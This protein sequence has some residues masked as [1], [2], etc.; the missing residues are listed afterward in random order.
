MAVWPRRTKEGAE[1][2]SPKTKTKTKTET[3]TEVGS[4]KKEKEEKV[5]SCSVRE[6]EDLHQATPCFDW[7]SLHEVLR[8]ESAAVWL[9]PNQ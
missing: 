4:S 8:G 5:V 9:T 7:P 2:V 1:N 6:S 3:E